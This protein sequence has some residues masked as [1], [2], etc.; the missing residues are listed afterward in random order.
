M[1]SLARLLA[2]TTLLTTLL[3]APAV[4]GC[5]ETGSAATD[6]GPDSGRIQI[7]CTKTECT[8][9]EGATC[10]LTCPATDLCS[11]KCLAGANCDIDCADSKQC[12]ARCEANS[13][14]LVRRRDGNSPD[15]SCGPGATCKTCLG[16]CTP[17]K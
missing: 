4:A 5:A 6:A 11:P 17:L 10:T 15:L 16:P 9:P 7:A 2:P 13:T 1:A 8:C 12:A 3:L 14:C